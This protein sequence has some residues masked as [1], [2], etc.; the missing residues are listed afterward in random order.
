M[1]GCL[2]ACMSVYC[3]NTVPAEA[4]TGI[5]SSETRVMSHNVGAENRT[6][7]LCRSSQCLTAKS[8]LQPYSLIS[9]RVR[10]AFF[11]F[12]TGQIWFAVWGLC[13]CILYHWYRALCF[14]T[15]ACSQPKCYF[16]REGLGFGEYEV[17]IPW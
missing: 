11:V 9:Y 3:I 4:R 17:Y 16:L 15:S 10:W 7:V 2:P 1:Y 5:R 8:S 6:R 12:I 14:Q 13:I